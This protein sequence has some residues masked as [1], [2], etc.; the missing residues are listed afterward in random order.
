MSLSLIATG[1]GGAALLALGF[2]SA[3]PIGGGIAGVCD[4]A[5]IASALMFFGLLDGA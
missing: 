4:V 1:L 2:G 3:G 5:G